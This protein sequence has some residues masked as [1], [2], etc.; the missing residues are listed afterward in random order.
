[1]A[2]TRAWTARGELR[3]L[4]MPVTVHENDVWLHVVEGEMHLSS[5]RF[6]TFCRS[7]GARLVEVDGAPGV[8]FETGIEEA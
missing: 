7:C 5:K 1:M 8:A 4:V 3:R 2:V 6:T